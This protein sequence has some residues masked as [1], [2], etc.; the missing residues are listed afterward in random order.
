MFVAAGWPVIVAA[1][2]L[3]AAMPPYPGLRL[4]VL[5]AAVLMFT[6]AT[7]APYASAITAGVGFLI[8]RG[9]FAASAS[10]SDYFDLIVVAQAG[11]FAAA[12]LVGC[13]A[14]RLL[15]RTTDTRETRRRS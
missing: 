9:G 15:R 7:N 11:A 14:G 4:A 1:A 12:V 10:R 5:L 8:F 2:F 13:L 6:A 3:A